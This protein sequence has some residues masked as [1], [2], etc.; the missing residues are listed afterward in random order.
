MDLPKQYQYILTN[1]INMVDIQTY[2]SVLST[3]ELTTLLKQDGKMTCDVSHPYQ[4]I[5]S[6]TCLCMYILHKWSSVTHGTQCLNLTEA[7][8]S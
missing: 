6:H 8:Q 2:A 3:V 1:I 4:V 7:R 5:S